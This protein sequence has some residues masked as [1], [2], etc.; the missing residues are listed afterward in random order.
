MVGGKAVNT[1]GTDPT[2]VAEDDVAIFRT[3]PDRRLLVSDVSP[4][5]GTVADTE[6]SAQTD[7]ELIAAPGAGLSL[8]IT[9]VIVSN[10]ATAGYV[11]FEEDTAS[12]KTV[13]IPKL[14]LGING[15]AVMNFRTPIRCTANKN[16]GMT[17]NTVTTHTALINYYIAP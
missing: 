7:K 2:S 1:D 11:L 17:S 12:A 10:G 6:T 13:K 4:R 14:Y 9:D 5:L 15:G 16:F 8:Y 3:S